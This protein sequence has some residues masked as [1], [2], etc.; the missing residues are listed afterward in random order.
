MNNPE[1]LLTEN[2]FYAA[3]VHGH[4]MEPLLSDHRDTVYIEPCKTYRKRDVILF[5]RANGQLVLHRLIRTDGD[6]FLAR[7]DND[8]KA[9]TVTPS[10]ILGVMTAFTR[11]GHTL[12]VTSRRY[13]LYSR[14][15]CL[16]KP[17]TRLLQTVVRIGRRIR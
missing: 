12:Y 8:R 15:W 4:S 6:V 14:L 11:N 1:Q 9:E 7:G 5:R 2:G 17:T 10:Q 13:R 16:S 3:T